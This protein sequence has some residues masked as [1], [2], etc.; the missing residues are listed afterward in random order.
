[1]PESDLEPEGMRRE[2]RLGGVRLVGIFVPWQAVALTL[3]V[4][5]GT[6][7]LAVGRWTAGGEARVHL[8]AAEESTSTTT[9]VASTSTTEASTTTTAAV[10]TSTSTA[11]PAVPA[12]PRP[13]TTTST[14]VAPPSTC[15]VIHSA[16]TGSV[17][18]SWSP[19]PTQPGSWDRHV[20]ATVTNPIDQP[21]ILGYVGTGSSVTSYLVQLAGAD[22]RRLGVG[23]SVTLDDTFTYGGDH[24]VWGYSPPPDKLYSVEFTPV[25]APGLFC[26][27]SIDRPGET[28]GVK[29]HPT[30]P[31]V[32]VTSQEDAVSDFVRVNFRANG[33]FAN[34]RVHY[35]ML[36]RDGLQDFTID[37]P[38]DF[39]GVSAT[40]LATYTLARLKDYG[41]ID[42]RGQAPWFEGVTRLEWNGTSQ[43]CTAALSTICAPAD[44]SLLPPR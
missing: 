31:T 35:R 1:M 4:V 24:T 29:P 14:T 10:A 34:L 11:K 23:E 3:A 39:Q 5:V 2:G 41:K 22:G 19:N 28:S 37:L 17:S 32:Y 27:A 26:Q 33:L 18:S 40:G 20:T 12:A 25:S 9:V 7:A 16:V 21:V 43:P 30:Q 6:T 38:P 36:M 8:A 13:T 44:G 15:A 42:S